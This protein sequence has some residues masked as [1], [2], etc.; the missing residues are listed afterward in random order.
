MRCKLK[1]IISFTLIL[2]LILSL[3]VYAAETNEEI[4]TMRIGM[5][6]EIDSLNPFESWLVTG[7]EFFSVIYDP[8]VKFDENLKPIPNLAESW[9]LSE[10]QL[11]WTFHLRQDVKFHDG[12]PL[13]S[14][15]VKFALG[16][17]SETGL[18]MYASLLAGITSIECPDDYTVVIHTEEPKANMLMAYT[19][20]VP[21]HIWGNVPLDE[22]E[23]WPDE[24]PVGSGPFK[25]AEYKQGEFLKI[26]ANDDYF[27]GRPHIDEVVYVFFASKDTMAQAIKLGEIDVATNLSP[28]QKQSLEAEE[29]IQ[30]ISGV[31]KG[32]TEIGFNCW[33]D[34]ASKGNKLLLDKSIRQAIE[35][36]IDKQQIIDVAYSGEG[37]FGTTVIDP[38]DYF[39]Y[40]P[41]AEE[42]R[43]YDIEKAKEILTAAGYEDTDGDGIR[44]DSQGNRLSFTFSLIADNTEEVKAGQ[45]IAG[46]VKDAGIELVVETVDESMLLDKTVAGEHDLF[47]W[48]WGADVDP[49]TIL[50]VMSTKEIGNMSDCFY[51]N[52]V[53][54]LLLDEQQAIM[55]EESRRDVVWEMQRILYEDVP[56]IILT[57]EV[58][59]QAVRTDRCTGW[60]QVPEGGPYFLGATIHN[61]M[62]V[63]PAAAISVASEATE[64]GTSSSMGMMIGAVV[65][66]GIAAVFWARKKRKTEEE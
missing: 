9:E 10:D 48:G 64:T 20:I 34:P 11:E 66:I 24:N 55:D 54:D 43:T 18:G 47:I 29:N 17:F 50:A 23:T 57:Y 14:E 35:W 13:T 15:D 59:L 51:S 65:I 63:Q 52:P 21:K 7:A 62:N 60:K 44:E 4:Y 32:Y 37:V 41:S 12:E 46:M 39:H 56:Y 31:V 53:Y 30:V 2:L 26:E 38:G 25:F 27:G 45:M 61:Y 5:T 49:T 33:D 19:P 1:K 42:L 40:E 6:Q 3:N 36:A 22:L 28:T 8:L 16:T 58:S